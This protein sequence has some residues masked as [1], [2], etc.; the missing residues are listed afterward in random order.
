MHLYEHNETDSDSLTI[1][2]HPAVPKANRMCSHAR[3]TDVCKVDTRHATCDTRQCDG[4]AFA[5]LMLFYFSGMAGV[6]F[7]YDMDCALVGLW[8]YGNFYDLA[9]YFVLLMESGCA[10]RFRYISGSD[11]NAIITCMLIEK[12]SYDYTHI[13]MVG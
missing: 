13:R 10:H 12:Y 2:T 4:V 7:G 8:V 9:S 6:Q 5:I 3:M 11:V 1:K